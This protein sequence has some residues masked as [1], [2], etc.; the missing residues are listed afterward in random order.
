MAK[1]DRFYFEN[2]TAAADCCGK[3]AVY[4][5]ECLQ[6]YDYANIKEMLEKMHALEHQAD[7]V[8]H[9]MTAALAKAFV[10]P[11][12][13]ED[14]ALISANIDEVADFIEEVLQRIYVNRIQTIM[15]EAITFAGMIVECCE[16]M[17]EMLL[18]LPNFKKP[19]KLHE[20]IIDLSHKEEECDRLYLEATLKAADFSND[21]LTVI[22]WREILDKLEKCADACEHVGDIVETIVMKNS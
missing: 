22:F 21:V 13:R 9:E 1:S 11:I 6:N 5:Q 16:M 4:L 15:P 17:K 20:M 18:E 19:K 14:M 12:D 10:T 2:F 7:G 3:A 8:K